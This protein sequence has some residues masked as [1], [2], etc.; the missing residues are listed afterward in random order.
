VVADVADAAAVVFARFFTRRG[1]AK[2]EAMIGDAM[3]RM[4]SDA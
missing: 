1:M 3:P 4:G 2:E